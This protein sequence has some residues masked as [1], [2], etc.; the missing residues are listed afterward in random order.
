MLNQRLP[1]SELE[2]TLKEYINSVD[3]ILKEISDLDTSVIFDKDLMGKLHHA[4]NIPNYANSDFRKNLLKHADEGDLKKFMITIGLAESTITNEEILQLISKAASFSWGDNKETKAFAEIFGYEQ[5]IIPKYVTKSE[6]IEKIKVSEKP[7]KTLKEYQTKIFFES[8]KLVENPWTRFIIRMP[9]GAGKTRTALE[10]VSHF[11]NTG[12][13]K[14]EK[15]QV[16]WIADREELC[17]QAIEAMQEIWPHIGKEE[18]TLYRA[19]GGAKI[20]KFEDFSFIVA[21]YQTLNSMLK[22]NKQF[23]TPHLVISDEAHNV[24]APTH[25]EALRK[26]E[27]NGT[28]IVGLTATPVRGIDTSENKKLQEY[29]NDQLIEIDSGEI[30]A[31]EFL[32]GEGY[33]SHY[34]PTTIPSNRQFNLSTDQRRKFEVERD[35]PS[36]LLD[37]I[38]SDNE[39]NIKIAEILRDLKEENSQILYFAPNVKQSKF[40]CALLLALGAKAAHVDGSSP[41]AYRKDVVEKFRKGEINFIFNYNVFSTGFDA[42]NIDVVFIARPTT[43]IVLHQQMIGRGMRGP[44]MGGTETFKLFRVVDDLPA[45]DL[46]DEYFSEIWN[47]EIIKTE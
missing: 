42:P 43:S 8:T 20:E 28:R 39:R 30:N 9:T 27:E 32:Q 29:F 21:T 22:N 7:L 24:L 3:F 18:L 1:R 47:P 2:Q 4:L 19:W 17:E 23:P 11:L 40:M 25:Q 34:I 46:A 13:E 5:S 37:E 36:G 31:I 33:L 41:S 12:L 45:I 26:L 15:R 14:D 6:T 10:V 44:K 35:L 16:V 38:A